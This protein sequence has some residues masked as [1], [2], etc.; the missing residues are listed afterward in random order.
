MRCFYKDSEKG[1]DILE[2]TVSVRGVSLHYLLKGTIN[3]G[4]N[5]YSPSE[6]AC[7]MLKEV[8]VGVPRVP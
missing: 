8:V 3:C 4:A 1:I 7:E 6:E 2:D 5:L